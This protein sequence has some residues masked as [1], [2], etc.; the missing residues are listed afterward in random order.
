MK[1][2]QIKEALEHLEAAAQLNPEGAHSV[3]ALQLKGR[4]HEKLG[5]LTEAVDTYRQA[6]L[7][8]PDSEDT[9]VPL[10]RLELATGQRREPLD[11]LRPLTAVVVDQ[12]N[13]FTKPP[14]F[15]PHPSPS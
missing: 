1:Q 4:L 9:L 11:L 6:L 8:E 5:Q 12:P 3:A 14:K 7:Q 2:N 10:V 13:D 15:H